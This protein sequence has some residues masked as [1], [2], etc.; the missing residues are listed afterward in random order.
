MADV[1]GTNR[2]ADLP[3]SELSAAYIQLRDYLIHKPEANLLESS[4]SS[5]KRA[6]W[7][8]SGKTLLG[9]DGAFYTSDIYARKLDESLQ[10]KEDDVLIYG[11]ASPGKG[12]SK[13]PFAPFGLKTAIS[14]GEAVGQIEKE[15]AQ[16]KALNKE[17]NETLTNLERTISDYFNRVLIAHTLTNGNFIVSRVEDTSGKV[18]V[19]GSTFSFR[20]QTVTGAPRIEDINTALDKTFSYLEKVPNLPGINNFIDQTTNFKIELSGLIVRIAGLTTSTS[21][22]IAGSSGFNNIESGQPTPLFPAVSLYQYSGKTITFDTVT[23]DYCDAFF[24]MIDNIN[25]SLSVPYVKI[26]I[27]DRLSKSRKKEPKMSLVSFLRSPSDKNIDDTIFANAKPKLFSSNDITAK[28]IASGKFVGI[29]TFL[30]PN[31]LLPDPT[32]LLLN[33]RRLNPSV[34]LMS[35][36][37]FNTSIESQGA[38]M[39]SRKRGE[40]SI[41]IHDRSRLN[42]VSSLVSLGDFSTIYF[43]IEWGY[44]HPHGDVSFNNPVGRYLN[45]MRLREI[46]APN[47]YTMTMGEGGSLT[48]NI[49]MLA[50]GHL[51]A[52]NT[53]VVTGRYVPRSLATRMLNNY[54]F[55][56]I[57]QNASS[58]ASDSV[59]AD[60]RPL[61]EVLA[62]QDTA[63][64][65]IK[66]DFIEQ[67]LARPT[68]DDVN[69]E[70]EKK[71]IEELQKTIAQSDET[72]YK[73]TD[74]ISSLTKNLKASNIGTFGNDTFAQMAQKYGKQ[75]VQTEYASVANVL[76]QCVGIPFA[77]TGLYNEVQI[78][79]FKF[80]KSAGKMADRP[81]TQACIPIE[82][83][84]GKPDEQGSLYN[85]DGVLTA[86]ARLCTALSNPDV[87]C[88]GI[89]SLPDP[90]KK[91]GKPDESSAA[92]PPAAGAPAAKAQAAAKEAK[93]NPP[94]AAPDPSFTIPNIKWDMR[95]IP[96]KIMP[97]NS[98]KPIDGVAD[99]EQLILQIIIYD[100][101]SFVSGTEI[102]KA[103]NYLSKFKGNATGR[104]SKKTDNTLTID[105]AKTISKIAYPN[106]TYGAVN[107][108]I[109]AISVSTN[110][111]S[112]ISTSLTIQAGQEAI[113]AQLKSITSSEIRQIQLIPGSIT[114]TI[115]GLPIIERGQ[116]IFLDLGTGTTLDNLYKV[117][118][119]RH[120]LT[121]DFTTDLTLQF[122][123]QGSLVNIENAIDDAI[124]AIEQKS[125]ELPKKPDS[126]L[127]EFGKTTGITRTVGI[128]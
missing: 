110:T 91:A 105:D 67:I 16:L 121:G 69:L 39:L 79:V 45:A 125:E 8:L 113:N 13:R 116:S 9:S 15:T 87:L 18:K 65:Y 80:N 5:E 90:S 34:P 59:Q 71:F 24:N 29:E 6:T 57:V 74:H 63:G 20:S 26:N 62:K 55:N 49:G 66:R 117:T 77:M 70:D 17:Y 75:V 108:V 83:F 78:H 111:R 12:S 44:I 82:D 85:T 22:S 35:L 14:Y 37:S 4:T 112:A 3:S 58:A 53:S 104:T 76:T 1:P 42:D 126:G 127:P 123:G 96:A 40:L 100:D 52:T 81:I 106:I 124:K 61:T 7:N 72:P 64:K 94:R 19:E 84:V 73:Q 92:S 25:L 68:R 56:V 32:D 122:A 46:Y 97:P 95:T 109:K 120:N 119:V 23:T 54:V 86:L 60:V 21:T 102:V 43:D 114:L 93:P 118:A 51:D 31:T 99:P 98:D 128:I 103:Y 2:T 30:S 50:A 10:I 33:P 27:I 28:R 107:S 41:V 101:N 36:L 48:I 115:L 88:Y 47:T 11:A 38:A 89:A